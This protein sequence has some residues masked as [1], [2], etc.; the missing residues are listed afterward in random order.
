MLERL[1]LEQFHGDER[2]AAVITN[3]VDRADV[4]MIQ[5]RRRTSLAFETLEYRRVQDPKLTWDAQYAHTKWGM[6]IRAHKDAPGKFD[7]FYAT[8]FGFHKDSVIKRMNDI[9]RTTK[10]TVFNC[11]FRNRRVRR[12]TSRPRGGRQPVK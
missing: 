1:A 8:F 10:Y 12:R 7:K 11:T 2:A 5:G 4:G 9:F 3:F 6:G